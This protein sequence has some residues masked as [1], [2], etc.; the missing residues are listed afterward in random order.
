MA[1]AMGQKEDSCSREPARWTSRA[2]EVEGVEYSQINGRPSPH[3]WGF[4]LVV[5]AGAATVAALLLKPV[6]V[7]NKSRVPRVVQLNVI[8][9]EETPAK[10]D[11]KEVEPPPAFAPYLLC[12]SVVRATG[13]EPELLDAQFYNKA[14]IFSCDQ[15]KVFSTGG[16]VSIGSIPATEVIAPKDKVGNFQD[17]GTATDSWLNTLTFIK[18]WDMLIEE[19]HWWTNDWTV[20][21]DPDA[22]FFPDRLRKKVDAHTGGLNAQP[23]WVGNCDR[24][25]HGSKPHLKLFGSLE[26]FS[27]N[28]VGTY[29]A[30]GKTCLNDLPWQGWG[31]DMY[32]QECMKKLKV[33][34]LN[35]TDFLGDNRCYPA[36][37]TDINRVAFHDFKAVKPFFQCWGQSKG[38][39]RVFYEEQERLKQLAEK[40]RLEREEAERLAA[41]RL[42]EER[43]I[44]EKEKAEQLAAQ[45]REK[46]QLERE[47]AL[48]AQEETTKAEEAQQKA[49]RAEEDAAPE[50]ESKKQLRQKAPL[51]EKKTKTDEEFALFIRKRK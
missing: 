45:E 5:F 13:Y 18:A 15:H 22:V 12:F 7:A 28:A 51:V 43:M 2:R 35:G 4:F 20:K 1:R 16:P 27:R 39:E 19:G 42:A 10:K 24:V 29:K 46:Q 44:A 21:V 9:P 6:G 32:M 49:L 23:L 48:R 3:K 50:K 11:E 38:S 25:W 41:Q 40:Q 8:S 34:A 36:P 37:C 26:V 30:W 14:G 33:K 31:E 47:A 17:K